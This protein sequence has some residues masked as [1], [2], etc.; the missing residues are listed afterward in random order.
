MANRKKRKYKPRKLRNLVALAA[1]FQPGVKRHPDRKKVADKKACRR[2][3][4]E[5]QGR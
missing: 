5:D 3:V 1:I 2:K 4:R